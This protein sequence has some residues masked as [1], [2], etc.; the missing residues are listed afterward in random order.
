M[1][2]LIRFSLDTENAEKNYY[3]AKWYE[4]IGHTAPAHT[5][6]LRAAERSKDDNLAYQSLIRASFSYRSQGSRDSTEKILLENA[7]MLLPE[8]PEAYYFLSLLYEKKDEWQNCYIYAGLGLEKYNKKIDPIDIVEFQGKHVLIFQKAV[9]SW[10]WGKGKECRDLFTCLVDNYWDN[11]DETHKISV[12]QNLNKLFKKDIKTLSQKFTYPE[13]FDWGDL[14]YED[15]STIEREVVGEQVYRFWNDVKEDDIVLDI[16]ASVGAYTV[17]ILDK[18]PK[19]VYCVEPSKT[20]LKL[21]AKNCSEYLFNYPNTSITYINNGIV[22]NYDDNINVFGNDKNFI[23]ITFK[24]LIDKY[25]IKKIDYMKVDCEGGEYSI[26]TEENFDFISNNVKFISIEIHLKGDGFREKFKNLRDNFI[27]RFKDYIVMSCT[28]QNI[29][30]GQSLDITQNI[31]DDE[32]IDTYG[33]EFMV[34][35]NNTSVNKNTSINL[36]N[37]NVFIDCGTHLFQGFEEISKLKK[38]DDSWDCYCFEANP[39]TFEMSNKKYL[40]LIE[41]GLNIKYFNNAISDT[42]EIVKVNCATSDKWDGSTIGSSTSQAS[43]ILMSPP[44]N[45]SGK[46]LDYKNV[47]LVNSIDFSNFIKTFFKKSDFIVVKL[48]IEGSE[49]NVLDK[50]IESNNIDYINEFYIEFHPHFFK[51]INLYNEKI[52]KYKTIFEEKNIKFTQWY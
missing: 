31:F 8:R 42:T 11:L 13:N 37:K 40:K 16:G 20:L 45:C 19:K 47:S 33:C 12:Q 5:Y 15:I 51:D 48:D 17:S 27:V 10:W 22:S 39:F 28:R 23:P 46:E 32:F 36:E 38:V 9:S 35:I 25:S 50:L 1:N 3:L 2:E 49:F 44:D 6:Y 29:N 34:Y 14:P 30:W 4:N 18:K 24:E 21:L 52:N 26:F 41:N 7:L 43:N